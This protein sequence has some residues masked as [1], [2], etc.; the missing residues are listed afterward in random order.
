MYNIRVNCVSPGGVF[1][2]QHS[3]FVNQ[4]SEKVPLKRLANP[5][6]ISPAVTFLLGD[7]ARYIT[8]HNLVVDGG[9]TAI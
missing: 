2:N 6:E 1:N 7:G 5:E 4:Y 3:N 8:G 9:W